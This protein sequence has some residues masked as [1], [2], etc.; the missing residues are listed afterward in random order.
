MDKAAPGPQAAPRARPDYAL[1]DIP[2]E[3]R[4]GPVARAEAEFLYDLVARL[5]PKATLEVGMGYGASAS[6]IIAAAQ[7]PHYAMDPFQAEYKD[8][9]LKNV[10]KLGLDRHL[11]FLRE[12]S[13]AALPRLLDQGVKVDF[14]FIDGGH[15]FDD[16]FI[17]FYYA[18]LLLNDGG[19]VLLHDAWMRST[20]TVAAWVRNNKRNFEAVPVPMRNLILFRKRGADDR[21]WN[22][23]RGFATWKGIFSHSL[24][25]GKRRLR[26]ALGR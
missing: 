26:A 13:H 10:A 6:F 23:F 17:D 19:H 1:L 15:R 22:H 9:G 14:A 21:P 7:A 2:P 16:I 12:Y 5:K 8:M 18:E 25:T 4:S 20:Q 3:E 24:N 11:H